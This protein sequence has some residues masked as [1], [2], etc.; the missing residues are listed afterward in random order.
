MVSQTKI[1]EVAE[2]NRTDG[3]LGH[4]AAVRGTAGERAF[5]PSSALAVKCGAQAVAPSAQNYTAWS[6]SIQAPLLSEP[7]GTLS[8]P[9]SDK[10]TT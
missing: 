4:N 1:V 5:A 6:S 7:A 3:I 2:L 10:S 8:V 9:A